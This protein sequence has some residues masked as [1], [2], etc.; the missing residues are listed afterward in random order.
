V[1]INPLFNLLL[2]GMMEEKVADAIRGELEKENIELVG[3]HLGEEDGQK[4]L[5]VTI[6][7]ENGVDIDLCVKATH[8]VDPIIDSLDLEI[9]DYVLDVG[10]K[11]V[12]EEDEN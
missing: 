4:T 9:E 8:I 5:F 2:G 12:S 10:S 11:G 1:G 7:S 3:V 6:D